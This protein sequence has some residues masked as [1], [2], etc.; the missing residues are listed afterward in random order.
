MKKSSKTFSHPRPL[1]KYSQRAREVF[2]EGSVARDEWLK[3]YPSSWKGSIVAEAMGHPAKFS[4]KLIRRIYEHVISEGWVKAGDRVLDPFGGVALGALDAMRFGLDW[5]GV[6]L[7]E[8]FFRIGNENISLWN[9]KFGMMPHWG[10][11]RLLHG[12]SRSLIG[13]I[14]RTGLTVDGGQLT[15]SSPPYAESI[16]TNAKGS[17]IDYSKAKSGGKGRTVGRESIAQG[18]G[19]SDGQLGMMKSS[20]DSYELVVGS[21]PFAQQQQGGGIA[22]ALNGR[23]DYQITVKGGVEKNQGYQF[24]AAISSPP[25]LQSEGGTPEPK[26]GGVIDA[27]LYKRHAAGN[28]SANGYGKMDGQL[29][30]MKEVTPPPAPPQSDEEQERHLERGMKAKGHDVSRVG[31]NYSDAIGYGQSNGQLGNDSGDDFWMAARVI[32][33]QVY[34]ALEVGGHACWVVKDYV[35]AKKIVPFA[36]QWRGLCEAAGFIT[37]HEHRAMLVHHKGNQ[38]MLDGGVHEVKTESKSFFRR[39]AEKKGSPR[40]DWEVV[41]CM[42]KVA[43]PPTPPQNDKEQERRLERGV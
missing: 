20:V 31:K 29:S 17:G 2:R 10:S 35:K 16:K 11:G 38:G 32:V 19:E 12:D 18:Y 4:S 22:D 15:V 33:E 21:P 30:S 13:L 14:G 3:C 43:P 6:E 25:F 5:T 7:E 8:K 27:K 42:V 26:V 24:D 9:G 36:N 37:V 40:I 1:P 41:L 34:E 23:S 28:K 39:L